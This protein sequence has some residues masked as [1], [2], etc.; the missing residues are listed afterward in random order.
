MGPGRAFS[1]V[2]SPIS[3][4]IPHFPLWRLA[5]DETVQTGLEN[6]FW[7]TSADL[8]YV[9]KSPWPYQFIEQTLS[10]SANEM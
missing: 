7:D 10:N 1:C 8:P 3:G 9:V 2:F 5:W 4:S 6:G